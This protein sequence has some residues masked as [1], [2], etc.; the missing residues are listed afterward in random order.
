MSGIITISEPLL[1]D[2]RLSASRPALVA[3]ADVRWRTLVDPSGKILMSN[4]VD[5]KPGEYLQF[6][7]RDGT[8]KVVK[9]LGYAFVDKAGY[10]IGSDIHD[11]ARELAKYLGQPYSRCDKI[12]GW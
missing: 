8:T 6:T 7:L 11:S 9:S 10:E 2:V 3:A 5:H 12:S 4:S 1:C